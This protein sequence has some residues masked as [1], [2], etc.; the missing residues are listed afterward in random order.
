MKI[1]NILFLLTISFITVMCAPR[2]VVVVQSPAPPPMWGPAGYEAVRY[3]YLPDLMVY[4]DVHTS[5][6]IYP[7][8]NRWIHRAYLPG[9]YGQFDL[10]STYKVVLV[11]YYGPYP[12]QNFHLHRSTYAVGYRG[13]SAQATIGRRDQ[14]RRNYFAPN[15]GSYATIQGRNSQGRM[16]EGRSTQRN[17]NAGRQSS[18]SNPVRSNVN[19]SD[20]TTQSSSGDRNRNS[21]ANRTNAQDTDTTPTTTQTNQPQPALRLSTSEMRTQSNKQIKVNN[22]LN[23]QDAAATRQRT[24]EI[25]KQKSRTTQ[26]RGSSTT[27]NVRSS[28][29]RPRG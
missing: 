8:G 20:N 15:R 3:Y 19:N 2:N 6:F 27:Q 29:S 14:D 24:Q 22:R 28:T 12:Y 5:M 23:T 10:Y 21:T 16:S 11:D 4:Y 1:K 17:S 7:R 25:R 9:Y 18:N 13:T 26:S